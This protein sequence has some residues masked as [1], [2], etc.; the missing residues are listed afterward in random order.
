VSD[1]ALPPANVF[2]QIDIYLFDQLLK[3]RISP[4]MRV[5]DAGCGNGRNIVYLLRMGCD[6]CAVDES[7]DAVAKTFAVARRICP[8]INSANF[9]V[10]GIDALPFDDGAFD[11]VVA[12]AVLHFARDPSHFDRMIG[13]LWR[14]LRPGGLLFAR[15]ASSIGIEDRVTPLGDRRFRLPDGSERYLVDEAELTR[16]TDSLGGALA[17][18]VK[19]TNVEN[20]RAMTTWTLRK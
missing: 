9:R 3:G 11:V 18:P 14:V 8:G 16:L 15:L 12:I 2:G 10:A 20:R 7:D 13:E 19:T 1:A 6:V 17:D 5:L 4:N